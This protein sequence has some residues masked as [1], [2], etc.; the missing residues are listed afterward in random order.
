MTPRVFLRGKGDHI[1]SGL[2][3]F[4]PL[5]LAVVKALKDQWLEDDFFIFEGFCVIIF[6]FSEAMFCS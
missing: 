3:I 2:V 5:K 4:R 1:K 6:L